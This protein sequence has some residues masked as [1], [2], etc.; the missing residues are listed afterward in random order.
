MG[1]QR[2]FVENRINYDH[3]RTC[4]VYGGGVMPRKDQVL[5]S[6]MPRAQGRKKCQ[7]CYFAHL[8]ILFIYGFKGQFNEILDPHFCHN[9]N[10]PGALT[11][12]LKKFRF[13]FVFAEIFIFL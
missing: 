3:V 1:G 4:F 6:T 11:N 5:A 13:G 2:L 7:L 10:Q 12:E 9:S 8:G